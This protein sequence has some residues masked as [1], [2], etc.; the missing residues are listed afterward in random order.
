MESKAHRTIKEMKRVD[1]TW[2][3]ELWIVNNNQYCG[4]MLYVNE[5]MCCSFHHHPIK[6]ETFFVHQG[7]IRL[8]V[9]NC[10]DVSKAEIVELTPTDAYDLTPFTWHRFTAMGGDAVIYEFSTR[11]SDCDVVRA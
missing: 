5:G 1:K 4:K 8:E 11:H 6:A 2:G 3:Y 10:E 7:L 9:G